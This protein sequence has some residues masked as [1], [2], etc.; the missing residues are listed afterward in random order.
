MRS[1]SFATIVCFLCLITISCANIHFH[2]VQPTCDPL[3]AGWNGCLQGQLCEVDGTYVMKDLR[4]ALLQKTDHI[5]AA[6]HQL[7]FMRSRD[8]LTHLMAAVVP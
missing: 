7:T 1:L 4:N 2:W 5:V 3:L 6:T 8:E